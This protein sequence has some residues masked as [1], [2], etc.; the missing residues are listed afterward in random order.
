M[1]SD[2][3]KDAYIE[4]AKEV[5]AHRALPLVYDGLKTVQRRLLINGSRICAN[6]LV[7]SATIIGETMANNHPH[8]DVSLYGTLVNMVND[9]EP[10]FDGQGNWGGY[11]TPYAAA[12]YT[13]VRLS[14]FA[15]EY[16]LPYIKYSEMVENDLGHMENSY[17]PTPIPYALVNGT[18]GI[19]TGVGTTIPAFTK[20]SL[21]EYVKWLLSPG[22]RS[23]PELKVNWP[24]YEIDSE[25]L[26][27]GAGKIKY[28]LIY[29]QSVLDETEVFIIDGNPPYFDIEAMLFKT[30]STEIDANKV[31]I[32][33][34]SGKGKV[35][36]IVGKV[37]WINMDTIREKL[38]GLSKAVSIQMIW[39]MG[40]N[41]KPQTKKFSPAQVLEESLKLYTKAADDWKIDKMEKINV[42]IKFHTIKHR[43][44]DML[45]HK[46]TWNSIQEVIKLSDEEL[47]FVKTKSISQLSSEINPVPELEKSINKIERTKYL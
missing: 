16:Y 39:S 43:I 33:N 40:P 20:D 47:I 17:I 32:R 24:D 29:N 11:Q 42:E 36:F 30:F 2:R 15:I 31:F 8:S 4:Y 38:Q 26:T 18:T 5:N 46:Q 3:I 7:K 1:I 10:M 9:Y 34:E 6:N 25:V 44:V 14:K 12:R 19:G 13:S 45:F 28:N 41:C 22:R 35:R 23:A 27:T 21:V 37:R